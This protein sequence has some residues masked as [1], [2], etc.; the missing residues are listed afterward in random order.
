MTGEC[1]ESEAEVSGR[2]KGRRRRGRS[3]ISGLTVSI[4]VNCCFSLGLFCSFC[5]C[6]LV[7]PWM[8]ATGH[9]LRVQAK[10][11]YVSGSLCICF[12]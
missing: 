3:G 12:R 2:V 11:W 7:F 9:L 1:R 6:M 8:D 5:S 4:V 10:V